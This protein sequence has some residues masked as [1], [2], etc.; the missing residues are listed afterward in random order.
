MILVPF[1]SMSVW[2]TVA[3]NTAGKTIGVL[4]L[5]GAFARH[6]DV[7]GSLGARVVLIK[8]ASDL[9]NVDGVVLPGGESTT[10]IKLLKDYG[11]WDALDKKVQAGCPVFS[12]CAGTVLAAKTVTQP[13]QESFGWL[14]VRVVRNAYGDQRHSFSTEAAFLSDRGNSSVPLVFIRAPKIEPLEASG[15]IDDGHDSLKVLIAV[16]DAP[17]L[18]EYRNILAATF[19]PELTTDVSIY[20]YWLENLGHR[21]QVH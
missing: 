19:H 16:D 11:I 13:K 20:R 6:A 12:T 17:V 9:E 7:L 15:S 14:P 4:A 18:V 1:L 3:G 5:Q 10:Q 21:V 8:S 2:R